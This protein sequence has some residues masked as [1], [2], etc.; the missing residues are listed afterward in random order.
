MDNLTLDEQGGTNKNG[1]PLTSGT[2]QCSG[3]SLSDMQA[4]HMYVT[5]VLGNDDITMPDTD[6]VVSIYFSNF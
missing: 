3:P 4:Q 5:L 6:L 1:N 2:K